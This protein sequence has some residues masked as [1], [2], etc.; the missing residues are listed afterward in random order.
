M[1]NSSENFTRQSEEENMVLIETCT[2]GKNEE[3]IAF[4]ADVDTTINVWMNKAMTVM[5]K[6]K[7][8]VFSFTWMVRRFETCPNSRSSRVREKKKKRKKD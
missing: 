2:R 8:K 7:K 5:L 3:D 6:W 4:Q 1:A